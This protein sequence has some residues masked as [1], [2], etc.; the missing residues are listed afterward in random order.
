MKQQELVV[1]CIGR[2]E[3]LISAGITLDTKPMD[4]LPERGEARGFWLPRTKDEAYAYDVGRL[5]QVT[6]E[7]PLPEVE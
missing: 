3:D 5:Y 4:S 2:A 7:G 1:R 6:I